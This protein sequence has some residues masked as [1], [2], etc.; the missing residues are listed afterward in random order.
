MLRPNLFLALLPVLVFLAA[1]VSLDSY[2][3]V[4]LR[5]VLLTI[6]AFLILINV[7]TGLNRIWFHWPVAALVFIVILRTVG[8]RGSGSDARK[9]R[10]TRGE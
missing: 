2:K 7:F 5:A 6:A 10:R 9:E 4:R 8:R 1:L 3:L